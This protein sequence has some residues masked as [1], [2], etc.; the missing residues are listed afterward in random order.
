M[1]IAFLIIS[2]FITITLSAQ[3]TPVLDKEYYLQKSRQQKRWG[4]AALVSG[5][6]TAAVGGA[7]W[8][9]AP[10]AGLSETGDVKGA[11]RTGKTLVIAGGSIAALSIPLYIA[12][13]KNREKAMLYTGTSS[14]YVPLKGTANQLA[15]GVRIGI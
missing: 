1:R 11:E 5:S 10:I 6:V 8:F 15:I 7:I 4:T 2:V 13:K 12:S 3:Q 9:L 14:I